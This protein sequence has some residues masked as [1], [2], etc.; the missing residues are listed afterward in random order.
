MH[1]LELRLRPT[2]GPGCGVRDLLS[3][4]P[5]F[6]IILW[7]VMWW[8]AGL[9]K[10][11]AV[12]DDQQMTNVAGPLASATMLMTLAMLIGL[13][14]G[15]IDLSVWMVCSA[16]ALFSATLITRG[17]GTAPALAAT[18]GMGAAIGGVQGLVALRS[19]LPAVLVTAATALGI[20]FVLRRLCPAEGIM[21]DPAA[22][23]NWLITVKVP[24]AGTDAVVDEVQP[25]R[26]SLV[27]LALTIYAVALV[28]V[29]GT[30]T[31]P[32]EI[33]GW[34]RRWAGQACAGAIAALAGY[35]SLMEHGWADAPRLPIGDPTVAAALTLT[36]GIALAGYFR[37]QLAGLL[38]PPATLAAVLWVQRFSGMGKWGIEW[39]A[40]LL[41]AVIATYHGVLRYIYARKSHRIRQPMPP[42]AEKPQ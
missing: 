16:G 29:V 4:G 39:Q 33:K 3:V 9:S 28:A 18:A 26:Y 27:L 21:L 12:A 30:L 31:P 17:V 6:L 10:D 15:I 13:R 7:L 1:S 32:A 36:G 24:I 19:R 38:T 25:L 40:V 8:Q 5:T 37:S 41:A 42:T 34:C 35:C 22:F 20:Y 23:H 11:P 2:G 14:N